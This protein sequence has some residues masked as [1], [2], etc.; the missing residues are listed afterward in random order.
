MAGARGVFDAHSFSPDYSSRRDGGGGGGRGGGGGGGTLT[1]G[2][3]LF[4]KRSIMLPLGIWR[5]QNPSTC[6]IWFGH[7]AI[8]GCFRMLSHRAQVNPEI[9]D[10]IQGHPS[11][12]ID[13]RNR[14]PID[15][16]ECAT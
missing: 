6:L 8:P 4:L 10:L 1:G 2:H 13:V 7:K 14:T 16:I 15:S 5:K 12:S 3:S 11:D 9:Y